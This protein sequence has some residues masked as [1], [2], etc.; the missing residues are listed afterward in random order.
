MLRHR[1]AAK[2]VVY[3]LT[4]A[5]SVKLADAGPFV[6]ADAIRVTLSGDRI[7]VHV[8]DYSTLVEGDAVLNATGPSLPLGQVVVHADR[9]GSTAQGS[10]ATV[11]ATGAKLLYGPALLAGDRLWL[12]A[13]SGE[14]RLDDA[15][16]YMVLAPAPTTMTPGNPTAYFQGR[17]VAKTGSVAYILNGRMTLCDREEPHHEIIARR[18]KFDE[19]TGDIIVDHA[20]L[21]LYGLT[22]PLVP[23]VKYG[24]GPGGP[25]RGIGASTPGYSS[26]EGLY[27]P[28][29][30]KLGGLDD[31][32]RAGTA[33]R[34]TARQGVVGS[35]WADR[36]VGAG[37]LSA[38]L[39]RKEWVADDL[40]DRL[41]LYR[42]PEINYQRPLTALESDGRFD[43]TLSLGSYKEDLETQHEGE[44]VRPRVYEQRALAS[45][46][47]VAHS[48]RYRARRGDWYGATGRLSAYS[49]GDRYRELELF[50]GLGGRLADFARGH[51]T[52][53][54][55]FASGQTPFLF[56]D[57]DI[58]TE[59]D[60]GLNV[61]LDEKWCVS[62]WGR[63]DLDE[64]RLRDYE[65]SL[66]RRMHCLTW[67]VY[68]Q[69]I[70]DRVGVRVNLNGLT[71]DTEPFQAKSAFQ[72]QMEQEGLTVRPATLQQLRGHPRPGATRA[73]PATAPSTMESA[74]A[75]PIAAAPTVQP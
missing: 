28:L 10:R 31:P 1:D 11:S 24:V 26:R 25:G 35:L 23:W 55:H 49:T 50:A 42:L 51:A 65:V 71:G 70:G 12:D 5:A 43:L 29:D 7:V 14:F 56:D 2:A 17:R 44:P 21:R 6:P 52:L 64:D 74:T 39:S 37:T 19:R 62:G 41:G 63:Y 3:A 45:L 15:R 67:D 18:I 48:A 66:R 72:A 61:R 40:E 68:Y 34:V 38:R 69:A 47:Y 73:P 27:L 4:L 20:K 8:G 54:H 58:K 30:R 32:W 53:R 16:G 9:V 57:V 75:A 60:S 33:L 59:L 13:A 36:T 46:G 22:I